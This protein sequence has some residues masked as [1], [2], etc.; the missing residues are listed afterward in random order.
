MTSPGLDTRCLRRRSGHR[1]GDDRYAAARIDLDADTDILGLLRLLHLRGRDRIEESTVSLVADC[2]DHP[3]R[4]AVDECSIV[5]LV[6][7][8]PLLVNQVPGL[9]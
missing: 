6:G 9:L 4:R 7:F 2:G 8:G 5:N 3:L 1:R